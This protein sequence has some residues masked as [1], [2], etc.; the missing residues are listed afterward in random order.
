MQNLIEVINLKD[1]GE[2]TEA[3]NQTQ[4]DSQITDRGIAS[5]AV[6]AKRQ[7]DNLATDNDQ[8][9]IVFLRNLQAKVDSGA[10]CDISKEAD[11][12]AGR[13]CLKSFMRHNSKDVVGLGRATMKL[14]GDVGKAM[15]D[16]S[17][18][19]NE[20]NKAI[21]KSMIDLV[22]T[23]HTNSESGRQKDNDCLEKHL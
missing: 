13:G 3:I 5:I 10:I 7:M 19:P 23:L 14:S 18:A 6:L 2:L 9:G 20:H 22:A 16:N 12:A 21:L 17:Y 8:A 11:K 4:F 1:G 15:A